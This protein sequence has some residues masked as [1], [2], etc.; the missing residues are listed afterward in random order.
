[1]DFYLL[2]SNYDSYGY[3][4]QRSNKTIESFLVEQM[5][6]TNGKQCL[7]SHIRKFFDANLYGAPQSQHYL[8]SSCYTS[9]ETFFECVSKRVMKEK[10]GG[11]ADEKDAD[12]VS[13]KLFE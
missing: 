5:I 11:N 4:L 1:M 10:R 13:K 8:S 12:S 7:F 9:I 2:W 3:Q 6:K